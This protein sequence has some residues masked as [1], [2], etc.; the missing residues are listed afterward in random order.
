MRK[1]PAIETTSAPLT[2]LSV[3]PNQEDHQ[4]LEA[5]IGHSR[6]SLLKA[7]KVPSARALLQAHY[8][9][10]VLCESDLKPGTWIDLLKDIQGMPAA[11]ALIVTSRLA[12]DYL[13]AEALNLG[14]WDVL[15]KPFDRSEVLR[16]VKTA[17]QHWRYQAQM[18]ALGLK[19]MT[20]AS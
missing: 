5:I 10:V 13:W 19:V 18:P 8:I 4:S 15:P 14:A 11:P 17:W 16:S 3:S 1:E 2:V 20:A 6:W 9:P 12:D 7:D